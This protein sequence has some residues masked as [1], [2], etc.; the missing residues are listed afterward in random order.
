[1]ELDHVVFVFGFFT[2][3]RQMDSFAVVAVSSVVH[4]IFLQGGQGLNLNRVL[5]HDMV[6]ILLLR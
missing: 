5:P 3:A 2:A 1:M 4:T 6:Y